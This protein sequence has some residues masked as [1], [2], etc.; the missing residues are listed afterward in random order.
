MYFFFRKNCLNQ[1]IFLSLLKI[2]N[3]LN[4]KVALKKNF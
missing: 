4:K 2:E 1:L 3:K